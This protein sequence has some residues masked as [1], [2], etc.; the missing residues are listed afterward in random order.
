MPVLELTLSCSAHVQTSGEFVTD[1]FILFGEVIQ[2][3][4]FGEFPPTSKI[5]LYMYAN[6]FGETHNH[7]A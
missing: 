4:N 5:I 6:E 2:R 1:M 7:G 3:D